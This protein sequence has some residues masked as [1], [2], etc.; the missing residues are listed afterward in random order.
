[1]LGEPALSVERGAAAV[2]CGGDRL[3]V[4]VVVHVACHEDSVDCGC[5]A[6]LLHLEVAGGIYW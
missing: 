5:G 2:A 4:A 1:M 6:V 3:A